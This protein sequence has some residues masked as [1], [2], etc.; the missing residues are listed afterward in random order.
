MISRLLKE[1]IKKTYNIS[2]FNKIGHIF[3]STDYRIN[4]D[5]NDKWLRNMRER[6]LNDIKKMLYEIM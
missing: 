3:T 5:S 1:T 6:Y 4:V 2:D